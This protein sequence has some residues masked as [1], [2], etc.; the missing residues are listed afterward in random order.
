MIIISSLIVSAA[1]GFLLGKII[2]YENLRDAP[3]HRV[4]SSKAHH[5]I[6]SSAIQC[7]SQSWHLSEKNLES[8]DFLLYTVRVNAALPQLV[9]PFQYTS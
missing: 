2:Q 3:K 1:L 5:S 6:Y 8:N 9:N 4:D 7:L